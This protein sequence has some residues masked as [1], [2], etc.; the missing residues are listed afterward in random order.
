[1]TPGESLESQDWDRSVIVLVTRRAALT[2]P[3]FRAQAQACLDADERARHARFMFARDQDLF[4]L[5]HALLRSAL[6]EVLGCAPS[7]LQFTRGSHGKP[8]L[9]SHPEVA[10]NLSHSGDCAA[11]A[12]TRVPGLEI[13]VDVEAGRDTRDLEGLARSQFAAAEAAHVCESTGVKRFERF[14][15]YW[16]LKEACIKCVGLG[17]SMDL[18]GFA[19]DLQ[20]HG[21]CVHHSDP[22]RAQMHWHFSQWR[23]DAT[24]WLAVGGC[25]HLATPAAD[26]WRLHGYTPFQKRGLEPLNAHL[27]G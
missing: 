13:G 12:I 3:G 2:V 20:R 25:S 4:L 19:F 27:N 16:T 23:L 5:S 22:A 11:L 15:R 1:M 10:F 8:A 6:A 7:S 17:L 21:V 18:Q 24:H 14:Y 9:P 26:Q